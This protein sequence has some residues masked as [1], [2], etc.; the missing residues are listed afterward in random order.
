[1]ALSR[2]TIRLLLLRIAILAVLLRLLRITV[3]LRVALLLVIARL[4][5]VVRVMGLL[6]FGVASI[7]KLTH[8]LAHPSEQLWNTLGSEEQYQNKDDK[9]D[10]SGIAQKQKKRG[11]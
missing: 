9:D 1:M 3:L 8:A 2:R 6:R 5:V 7:L 4:L 10:G 11:Q